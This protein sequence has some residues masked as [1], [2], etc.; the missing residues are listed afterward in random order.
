MADRPSPPHVIETER[1]LLR[2]FELGDVDDV[3]AYARD[4]EWSRYLR[5]LPRPYERVH[6]EQ[7]IARQILLDQ[8]E[9]VA[10]AIVAEHRVVGGIGLRFNFE[11]RHAE[12]GYSVG[13]ADWGKGYGTEAARA[14]VDAGFRTHADL[15]RIHARADEDNTGSR[16]VMEKVGMTEEGVLRRYRVERGDA[17]NEVW[18]SILREEWE[19]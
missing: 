8:V 15:I 10:W 9:H 6:A 17:I 16:R 1:L 7:F 2:P 5:A 18:Y 13:R 19:D 14:V 12:L 11:H 4:A 3:Y